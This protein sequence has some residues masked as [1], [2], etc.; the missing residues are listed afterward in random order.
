[1]KHY[2]RAK[3]HIDGFVKRVNDPTFNWAWEVAVGVLDVVA[4]ANQ[5]ATLEESL[6]ETWA[7]FFE[8][9]EEGA[10]QAVIFGAADQLCQDCPEDQQ[11]AFTRA[12]VEAKAMGIEGGR[13]RKPVEPA[14]PAGKPAPTLRLVVNN[15]HK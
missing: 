8:A 4:V 12:L 2:K 14:K 13:K 10:S 9:L 6:Q 11:A 7:M 1:V 5:T 15:T 3:A